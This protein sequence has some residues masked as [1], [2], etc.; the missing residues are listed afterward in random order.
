MNM[1][2]RSYRIH[3]FRVLHPV[4]PKVC[5]FCTWRHL[6]IMENISYTP[7]FPQDFRKSEYFLNLFSMILSFLKFSFIFLGYF[8]AYTPIHHFGARKG[9]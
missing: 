9:S 5:I 7:L 1:L 6:K 2:F 3:D 4:L 8:D